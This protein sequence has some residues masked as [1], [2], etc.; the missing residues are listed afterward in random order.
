MH[1]DVTILPGAR[2]YLPVSVAEPYP[3]TVI[4]GINTAELLVDVLF[5][6]QGANQDGFRRITLPKPENTIDPEVIPSPTLEKRTCRAF[7]SE[8]KLPIIR[9][10]SAW[11]AG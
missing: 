1:P 7:S 4:S 11:R 10:L 9:R 5:V 6:H 2:H 8:Y 3:L